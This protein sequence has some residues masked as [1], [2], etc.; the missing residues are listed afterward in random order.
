MV[1]AVS[2]WIPPE[3]A[4]ARLTRLWRRRW[5]D[6]PPVAHL[7]RDTYR[8]VWVRFHSLPGSRRYPRNKAE[9]AVVL[10]RYNTVLD[11]LFAGDD[12]LLI[13]PVWTDSADVPSAPGRHHWFTSVTDDPDPQFRVY[14]HVLVTRRPWRT[15]CADPLLREVADFTRAGVMVTDTRMRRIHHPYDGGADVL[16]ATPE[17][18]DRLRDRHADWLSARQDGL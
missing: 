14:Q 17:E 15:G 8:D 3:N 7:L 13:T 4:D 16:L 1:D 6:C 5:P 18:R 9:Y 12:V 10:H 11:T 2:E